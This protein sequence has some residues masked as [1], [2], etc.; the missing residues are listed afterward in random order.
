MGVCE[1]RKF[2][3][4]S[5][6]ALPSVYHHNVPLGLVS[7]TPLLKIVKYFEF[8]CP[9]GYQ[10]PGV[11]LAIVVRRSQHAGNFVCSSPRHSSQNT[12][13]ALLYISSSKWSPVHTVYNRGLSALSM[14]ITIEIRLVVEAHRGGDWKTLQ[15]VSLIA[16]LIPAHDRGLG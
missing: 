9:P 4:S 16:N 3:K 2:L 1:T 7:I 12:S 6:N 10:H 13:T 8:V 5:K 11:I 15:D 14:C